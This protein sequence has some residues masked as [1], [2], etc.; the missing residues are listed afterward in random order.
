MSLDVQ[1]LINAVRDKALATGLFGVINGH[2]PATPLPNGLDAAVW[3]QAIGPSKQFSG[4]SATAASV[5]LWMRIYSKALDNTA[6][7]ADLDAIDP[8]I[9]DATS[10]M[11]ALLSGDFELGNTVLAVDLL[12]MNGVPL[13]SKA[14]NIDVSG[15]VYRIVDITIPLIIDAV[16]TQAP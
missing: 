7:P 1:A 14:G 6:T 13:S 9:G 2:E 10:S 3:M 12:G 4:L 15:T 5:I 16:W 8:A 11:M